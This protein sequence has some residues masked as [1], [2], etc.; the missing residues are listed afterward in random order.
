MSGSKS[1]NIE[2][3]RAHVQIN[4]LTCDQLEYTLPAASSTIPAIFT[5]RKVAN[6]HGLPY[7]T[8]TMHDIC[9]RFAI[10]QL[11]GIYSWATAVLLKYDVVLASIAFSLVY[12]VYIIIPRTLC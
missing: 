8:V 6:L 10:E 4:N 5:D 1:T 7:V 11:L 9:G 3:S 2:S 12:L